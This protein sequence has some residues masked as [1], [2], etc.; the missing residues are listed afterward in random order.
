MITNL[1]KQIKDRRYAISVVHALILATLCYFANN[2]S[3][4]VGED[5]KQHFITQE[6]VGKE[7]SYDDALFVNVE[8][9]KDLAFRTEDTLR[10]VAVTDRAKLYKLLSTLDSSRTYKYVILDVLFDKND[11]TAYDDSLYNLIGRMDN[12]VFAQSNE[13]EAPRPFLYQFFFSCANKCSSPI[14]Q[15]TE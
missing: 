1:I 9:D 6:I 3:I 12:I 11:S 2:F 13:I 4:I 5:L 14:F 15:I 7:F 10:K 8:Y